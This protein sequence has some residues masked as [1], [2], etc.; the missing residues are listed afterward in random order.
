MNIDNSNNL[1]S[2]IE[3][4]SNETETEYD[5][6]DK[7][8]VNETDNDNDSYYSDT[9]TYS[10][11]SIGTTYTCVSKID[12]I[13]FDWIDN[14][15]ECY[16]FMNDIPEIVK[17]KT[18]LVNN[19][20]DIIWLNDESIITENGT[21]YNENLLTYINSKTQSLRKQTNQRI[22]I[23]DIQFFE[24]CLTEDNIQECINRTQPIFHNKLFKQT[25]I[26]YLK[27]DIYIKPSIKFFHSLNV[28]VVILKLNKSNPNKTR[29]KHRSNNRKT[30]KHIH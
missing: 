15:D 7:K 2:M 10:N 5:N 25:T 16:E 23:D 20:N 22:L 13:D 19:N 29:K 18:I 27:D 14:I 28:L 17:I 6:N 21:I 11:S 9:D 1:L 26:N 8:T 12:D 4:L 30:R 3:A 24:C